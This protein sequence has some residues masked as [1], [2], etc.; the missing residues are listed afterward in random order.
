LLFSHQSIYIYTIFIYVD[1]IISQKYKPSQIWTVFPNVT[2]APHIVL[3]SLDI[4]IADV[5]PTI[6]VSPAF[7]N[8]TLIQV[9]LPR[10]SIVVS[11]ND[12]RLVRIDVGGVNLGRGLNEDSMNVTLSFLDDHVLS[13]Q[14]EVQSALKSTIHSI[15]NDNSPDFNV[16]IAGPINIPNATW[17]QTA[18]QHLLVRVSVNDILNAVNFPK[19]QSLVSPDGLTQLIENSKFEVDVLKD[20][21]ISAPLSL[22]IPRLL[23]LPNAVSISLGM[24]LSVNDVSD[25]P[26][27]LLSTSIQNITLTTTDTSTIVSTT[28]IIKPNNTIEASNK[29]AISI[30][31]ILALQLSQQPSTPSIALSSISFTNPST[32]SQ[33]AW[34]SHLFNS[35]SSPLTLPHIPL[36]RLISSLTNNGTSLPVSLPSLHVGQ[37]DSF[38]GFNIQALTSIQGDALKLSIGSL[39]L[40][41]IL[42][43]PSSA[44]ST[45]WIPLTSLS[46]PQGLYVHGN[47]SASPVHLDAK[48]SREKGLVNALQ[49]LLDRITSGNDEGLMKLGVSGISMGHS[50][51]AESII[52]FSKLII[53]IGM[54]DVVQITSNVFDGVVERVGKVGKAL[55]DVRGVDMEVL[56]DTGVNVGVSTVLTNPYNVSLEM[57]SIGLVSDF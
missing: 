45:S 43:P 20:N 14:S 52:T 18:T 8:P 31:P 34:S 51:D 29:L 9:A 33:Y 2:D 55:V 47:D 30:N 21:S 50:G 56:S 4:N 28:V 41:I 25:S 40:S 48:I 19:I 22:S 35:F 36:S 11:L 32:Q 39:S 27:S 57:G 37:S 5:G 12:A 15:L 53:E 10:V 38:P 49:S 1:S 13:P 6:N 7:E 24:S 42:P 54:D 16:G 3:N 23:P 17:L 26:I 46:F 44:S